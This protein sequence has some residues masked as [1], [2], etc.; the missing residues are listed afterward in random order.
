[1][2]YYKKYIK[3]KYKYLNLLTKT[4]R[5]IGQREEEENIT[6]V[7]DIIRKIKNTKLKDSEKSTRNSILAGLF[8]MFVSEPVYIPILNYNNKLLDNRMSN[9]IKHTYDLRGHEFKLRNED[10]DYYIGSYTPEIISKLKSDGIS[11]EIIDELIENFKLDD[12]ANIELLN[13]QN[14]LYVN[15][16]NYGKNIECWIADNMCCPCCKQKTL[17]HY[18]KDNMPCIDLVCVNS[19]HKFTDG[20]KFFQVKSKSVDVTYPPHKNFDYDLRQIHTGSK[21]IG[22]YIHSIQTSGDYYTLLF[23]YI[24]VEYKKIIKEPDEII[25][26]SS[27]SFIV[28]PKIYIEEA[29]KLFGDDE[30]EN[31]EKENMKTNLEL[32]KVNYQYHIYQEPYNSLY[33]WYIND[34]PKT[35]IIEFS[36]SN[37]DIVFF[38]STNKNLLFGSGYKM[39][40]VSTDYNPNLNRWTKISNPLV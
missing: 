27:N 8:N 15:F 29:K 7:T 19:K 2:D 12:I 10:K 3:Y 5:S 33:Y 17:R 13:N 4:K 39:E 36:V 34:E 28:L 9:S 6:E 35:N 26:I 22:Q 38:T 11:S 37:N 30:K 25:K 16:D 40:F 24:C 31:N 23:G 32:E 18:V 20:V 14:Q 21:A 1:M